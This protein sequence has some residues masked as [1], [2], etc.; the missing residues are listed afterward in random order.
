MVVAD[1]AAA[2]GG[3]AAVGCCNGLAHLHVRCLGRQF[4]GVRLGRDH[5]LRLFARFEEPPLRRLLL[6]L[7]LVMEH[8]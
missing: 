7:L 2:G 6:L 5:F 3:V 8:R 1:A 4:G